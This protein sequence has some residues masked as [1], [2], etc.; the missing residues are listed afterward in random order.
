MDAPNGPSRPARLRCEVEPREEPK[1]AVLTG[2]PMR[3]GP[4]ERVEEAWRA[5]AFIGEANRTGCGEAGR[6]GSVA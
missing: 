1:E 5:E 4:E 2:E 3:T 6:E